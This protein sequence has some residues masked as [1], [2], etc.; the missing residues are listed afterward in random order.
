MTPTRPFSTTSTLFRKKTRR[1]DQLLLVTC[2]IFLALTYIFEPGFRL[3]PAVAKPVVSAIKAGDKLVFV[4]N[5]VL[6]PITLSS[7]TTDYLRAML[8]RN[9][10]I[11]D[12]LLTSTPPCQAQTGDRIEVLET[13]RVSALLE[14]TSDNDP[15]PM[16]CRDGTIFIQYKARVA[17]LSDQPM[18]EI[19]TY[20]AALQQDLRDFAPLI[21]RRGVMRP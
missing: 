13:G 2:L 10:D 17:P 12:I 8:R 14:Y 19:A 7:T 3:V 20:K 18:R 9:E 11:E 5:D 15:V 21:I 16:S 1:R 6:L 4:D